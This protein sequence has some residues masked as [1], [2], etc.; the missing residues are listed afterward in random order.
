[1]IFST[2]INKI[3]EVINKMFSKGTLESKI[4]MDIAMSNQMQNH[5]YLCKQIHEN[6]AP[7]V[8]N[9]KV[10]SSNT[11]QGIATEFARLVTIEFKS[12]ISNNDFLNKEYQVVIDNIRNYTQ[13]ACAEGGLV[14]KPYV[15]NG[16][17]E[18][19][20]VRADMFFPTSFNTRGDILGAVFI[21]T[22]VTGD[23]TYTRLEIHDLAQNNYQ[24]PTQNGYKIRNLAFKKKNFNQY[25]NDNQL[26]DEITLAEVEDWARLEPEV[27]IRNVDRPLFAYFKM[28]CANTIDSTS[29]L[30][31]SV[32]SSIAEPNGLLEQIDKQ[33][34]KILWEYT[35]KEASIDVDKSMFK[36]DAEGKPIL[37]EGK[38]RLYQAL[39]FGK[40]NEKQNM[41]NVYSPDIRDV[42]LFNGLNELLRQAEFQVGLAYGTLS[43][44]EDTAKTATEI[45]TSKQRSYQTV[46][47]IQKS[48]RISLENLIY[49]MSI[50]GQLY[51]LPVKAVNF[52]D[53]SEKSD[54]SFD[55]D[56]SIV[57]DKDT[58]MNQ[59]YLDTSSGLIK[60]AYYLKKR[61][62]V[63]KKE[64]EEMMA[65]TQ[66]TVKSNPLDKNTNPVTGLPN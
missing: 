5:I 39:D 23:T 53:D 25:T 24:D 62:N 29:P 19:D 31:V 9:G 66:D 55:F 38:E 10:F 33:Y 1:M 18:V 47:D 48:L 30:G 6:K 12:E 59:L 51:K 7:W 46:K 21:E 28:P 45:K 41:W 43:K 26:G 40:A 34:S 14:F 8:D 3:K 13:F 16:H 50:L 27:T 32:Y 20:M 11:G 35:A 60:P 22:K 36:K 42:S 58:E 17:I 54:V 49:A 65:D 63:S 44:V 52:D 37:P 57:V 56:D 2:I 61:Y 15:S 64:L 4:K